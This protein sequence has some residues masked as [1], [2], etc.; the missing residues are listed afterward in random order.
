MN[1]VNLTIVVS[2]ALIILGVINYSIWQ[3]E[4]HLAN[5]EIIYLELAPVDP[6]SIMQGDYMTL[7]FKISRQI[8][9]A[10]LAETTE[11]K[12]QQKQDWFGFSVPDEMQAQ[13]GFVIV[14][15]DDDNR[16]EF[17][18]IDDG[19]QTLLNK[20]RKLQFR[21]REGRI[22][23]ATNAFFFEEGDALLFDTAKY[24]E[25]KVNEHGEVLL[26]GLLDESLKK[27]GEQEKD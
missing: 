2:T 26:T 16:A 18:S 24:G 19:M 25:L 21:V 27:L 15:L 3:K 10:I 6:R 1:K 17:A 14:N 22:K 20:Q 8:Q 11:S 4:T 23:F 5:G 13:E 12:G 7:A 9:S